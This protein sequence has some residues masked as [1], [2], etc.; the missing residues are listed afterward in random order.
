MAHPLGAGRRWSFFSNYDVTL[1]FDGTKLHAQSRAK[2]QNRHAIR[3]DMQHQRVDITL[4]EVEAESY[5][6]SVR[7]LR[8]SGGNWHQVNPAP[9]T[10]DGIFGMPV[11]FAWQP[12]S[13]TRLDIR[14]VVSRVE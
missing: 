12:E 7:I 6:A 13:T 9:L 3:I 10:F 14:I 4:S 2:L 1:S 11:E 5:E 8:N